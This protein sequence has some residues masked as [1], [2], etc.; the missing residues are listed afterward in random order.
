MSRI[1]Y[2][3]K[4][5][6]ISI[7]LFVI[8]IFII[9]IAFLEKQLPSVEILKDVQLQVPLRIYSADN[10]LIAEYGEKRRSP[11]NLKQVPRNFV[12]AILATEDRRFYQHTGVDL[13]SLIRA[14]VALLVKGTK[15]QGGSTITM[16]VARNFF[17]TSKKT[18]TR[19]INEILLALKI[20]QELS[21][22]EILELYLNKIYFGKRA[23]GIAAAA[24]VYYGTTI[25]N[26]TLAQMAMLAGL[27]Q[28]PS[29]INPLNSPSLALKRRT[30]VLDRMLAYD[31]IT[32]EQYQ[33]AINAPITAAYH[34]RPI[35][36]EAPFIAEMVRQELVEKF[37]EGI[38]DQ[39]IEVITTIDSTYQKAATIAL[40][41][42]ILEYDQRHEFRKPQVTFTFNPNNSAEEELQNWHKQLQ[43]IPKINCLIPGAITAIEN[44]SILVLL[45]DNKI[46]ELPITNIPWILIHSKTLQIG[47]IIY[48]Q[49]KNNNWYLAQI[50]EVE[51]AIV[52]MN[53]DN[54][55]ILAL[56]GGFDYRQSSFNRATQA[57][58]QPGSSFKPFIYSLALEN[59]FTPA[60][61]I[62]DA[63]IVQED[64]I[65]ESDWRPQN[66]T[67]TFYG[68]TRLRVGITKSR[69]LV[70][71]RI[72]QAIGIEK[73]IAFLQRLGFSDES[74][75][76]GLS[77]ALGT[78]NITPLELTAKFCVFPNG[79]FQV[80]P[81]FI[82]TIFN[83]QR[84]IIYEEEFSKAELQQVLSPQISYLITSLLQD[85]IQSGTG[86]RAL[87][88]GRKDLAGKTGTSSDH[89]DA[90][91]AG[92]NRDLVVTTWMGFDEPHSL[93]EYAV[94]SA[95]PMWIYFM[96]QALK[97]KAENSPKQPPGIITAKIDPITGLLARANQTDSI[98][99][100]FIEGQT[101]TQITPL[102]NDKSINNEETTTDFDSLF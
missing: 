17:L 6:F 52:A 29:A 24:E 102:L 45:Q 79:G 80:Q 88:L 50:P 16:Q 38:Y 21:K 13:R 31:F 92:Y 101:P 81:Y 74:L 96:E 77:L 36:L 8:P 86:K 35:E 32:V 23:Y 57:E 14:T 2:F 30:H 95:L 3:S 99:E 39:G 15:E 7:I 75:P 84:N 53:P 68:P 97:G 76:R 1:S 11:I 56:A 64:P 87:Q 71:I 93:K 46:I 82:N 67:K 98:Y 18:F 83:Y 65:N 55:A 4:K 70:S 78:N 19:K 91:Y 42:A 40:S 9:E 26:L 49:Q 25:D 20:E 48:M 47:N 85:A 73:A 5:I 89:F 44:N 69:N 66:H 63:P 72:L 41:K 61:I 28:A 27:P 10:K 62:N 94:K 22:D 54:G 58:R 33:E 90:W 37:G 59:G 12:N 60:S 43:N 51:G 100:L 34:G